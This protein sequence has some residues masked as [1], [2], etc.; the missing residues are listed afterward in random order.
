MADRTLLIAALQAD[1]NRPARA[2]ACAMARDI[3][4][5]HGDSV[6]AILFY[7]SCQRGDDPTGI[8][9]LYVLVDSYRAF[10]GGKVAAAANR[11]MPPTVFFQA[12]NGPTNAGAKVA[13]ISRRQ[14]LAK[15]RP[16]SVDTTLW[17]RFCQPSTL[18]YCR[19]DE[20]RL[21]LC[22]ALADATMTAVHWALRLGPA[23]G[24][25]AEFWTDL[26]HHTYGAELRTEK[27]D[28]A[29]T[30]YAFAPDR[31]DAQLPL[32][33]LPEELT[34]GEANI[35]HSTV[36]SH[37]RVA[38]RIRWRLRRPLGKAINLARLLKALFTFDGGLDYIVWKMERHSKQTIT[39]TP[40]QRRHPILAAPAVLIS[41]HRRGIIR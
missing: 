4:H 11:L 27:P 22:Q 15:M 23:Q 21:W 12:S 20:T 14:F 8:L 34:Q 2:D 29:N 13:V 9:D 7:G 28:R 24:S 25:A 1:L 37:R 17:A 41:L 19:D 40:W 36:P 26:L 39:L 5:R 33:A 35:F 10:H 6:A 3:A 32:A 18:V 38:A 30:V 16:N 31:F